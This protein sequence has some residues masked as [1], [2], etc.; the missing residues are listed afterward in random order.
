MVR[1]VS[2]TKCHFFQSRIACVVGAG[3]GKK[4][5]ESGARA[6]REG[7]KGEKKKKTPL[8]RRARARFLSPFLVP[9]TQAKSRG[10]S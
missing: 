5:G 2:P 10:S 1:R 6:T 3:K 4:E 7:S 9:T 8:A